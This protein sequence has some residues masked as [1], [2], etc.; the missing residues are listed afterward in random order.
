MKRLLTL[1][2]ITLAC[3]AAH[4][5]PDEQVVQSLL[6]STTGLTAEAVR[7]DYDACDSGV[8]AR[9]RICGAYRLAQEDLRLNQAYGKLVDQVGK[10]GEGTALRQAQRAW[11][12]YRD[13]QCPL[14]G[15]L[16]AGGG[17]AQGLFVQTCMTALTRQQADR[18]QA[19]LRTN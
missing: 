7:Q 2:S 14:E 16:G 6:R 15:R 1:A 8:T 11:I 17:T 19:A 10:G 4:A 18:L 12:A 3:A 5:A 9:M 13:A